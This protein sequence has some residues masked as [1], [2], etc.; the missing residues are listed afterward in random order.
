[1]KLRTPETHLEKQ[2]VLRTAQGKAA[3]G[4]RLER[5]YRISRSYI[6]TGLPNDQP[7]RVCLIESSAYYQTVRVGT[8]LNL[9]RYQSVTVCSLCQYT[10][11]FF[12]IKNFLRSF[13]GK[14]HNMLNAPAA[15]SPVA[16]GPQ[17][18]YIPVA[19]NNAAYRPVAPG[20]PQRGT[21]WT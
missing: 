3:M 14:P 21:S 18:A 1:M 17:V 16:T 7:V 15:R 6:Q 11:S 4:L 9:S 8:Y 12:L 2:C 19:W 10:R 13:P 5:I 20:P